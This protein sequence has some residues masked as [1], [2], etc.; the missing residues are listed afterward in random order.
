MSTATLLVRLSY[1][2]VLSKVLLTTGI[3]YSGRHHTFNT[4]LVLDF[5]GYRTE[6]Q[7]NL[8]PLARLASPPQFSR[9]KAEKKERRS[10][11]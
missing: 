8:R 4:T 2:P 1:I 10:R 6:I 7:L 9:R 3:H 11:H 5:Q